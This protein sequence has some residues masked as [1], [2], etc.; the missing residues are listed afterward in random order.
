MTAAT[1]R[2]RH[3]LGVG[4]FDREIMTKVLAQKIHDNWFLD[5]VQAARHEQVELVVGEAP[6]ADL[7]PIH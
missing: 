7:E 6:L 1:F 5:R 3:R 4:S 2:H